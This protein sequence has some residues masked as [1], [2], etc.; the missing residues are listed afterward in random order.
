MYITRRYLLLFRETDKIDR[1]KKSGFILICHFLITLK[2]C[3]SYLKTS[4]WNHADHYC[5]GQCI[6]DVNIYIFRNN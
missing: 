6:C 1:E 4:K 3:W 2:S 5:F